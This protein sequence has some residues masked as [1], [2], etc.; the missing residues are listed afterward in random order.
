MP[1]PAQSRRILRALLLT[2]LLWVPGCPDLPAQAERGVRA[3][4]TS[5]P[6]PECPGGSLTP[7]TLRMGLGGFWGSK[8]S[9]DAYAPVAGFLSTR[10]GVPVELVPIE[11][12]DDLVDKLSRG[13]VDVAK[14]PPLAY[15]KAHEKIPCLRLLR[16]MVVD[17]AVHYSGYVIVRRDSP[18]TDLRDLAGKR[19][20]FVERSSASGYLF[21]LARLVSAGLSPG[22]DFNGALFLG[23]HEA[24][25]RAVL[26]GTVDA[27][28]TFQGALKSARMKEIDTG[29]LRV[30]G[31]TGRIPLDALVV[32]PGLESGLVGAVTSALDALNNTSEKGR[33]ALGGLQYVNG[34][35]PTSDAFYGAVREVLSEVRALGKEAP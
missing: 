4:A 30:L 13:D 19:I 9:L 27:G 21:P 7:R 24:V 12:Y 6:P 32:R 31:V 35:V 34:W 3:I 18:V 25:I 5:G 1:A 33:K 16:T 11:H 10:I 26:D 23:S 20:A 14:L 17:G 29:S 28:A 8:D 22:P 15:V 2:T